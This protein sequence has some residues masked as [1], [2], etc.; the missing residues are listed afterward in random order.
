MVHISFF[1]RCYHKTQHPHHFLPFIC[2]HWPKID[3]FLLILS[4][5]SS[6][7][8]F[9][10]KCT[11]LASI[12]LARLARFSAK[13]CKS[14]T[15]NKAFLAICNTYKTLQE[16]CKK[17]FQEIFLHDLDH[18]LQENYLTIFLARLLQ[19]FNDLQEKLQF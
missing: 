4:S 13:S 10:K 8:P 18:M 6:K 1:S 15:K 3:R 2:V 19:N 16:S 5:K 7:F 12:F 14:C 9:C 17:K 11:N